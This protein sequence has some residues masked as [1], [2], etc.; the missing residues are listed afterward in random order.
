MRSV[1]RRSGGG[2][3]GDG[4]V[5]GEFVCESASSASIVVLC[6]CPLA[7]LRLR[8]PRPASAES[9]VVGADRG[10]PRVVEEDDLVR[11][12]HR[13]EPVRDDDDDDLIGSGG[14]ESGKST[15]RSVSKMSLAARPYS[16]FRGHRRCPAAEQ[17][18]P[19]RR[20]RAVA[21]PPLISHSGTGA[22]VLPQP[23]RMN[24]RFNSNANNQ[25]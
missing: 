2:E 21:A 6:R 24:A 19:F 1:R 12:F 14:L 20:Q 15:G 25:H 4:L 17:A 8:C 18:S 11:V 23:P 9:F 22:E 7:D 13:C 10:D 3:Q 16:S 5:G